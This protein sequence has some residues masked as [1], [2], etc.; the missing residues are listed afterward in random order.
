MDKEAGACGSAG[1]RSDSRG[2]KSDSQPGAISNRSRESGSSD[3]PTVSFPHARP[4][5]PTCRR[6][7]GA[8]P[9]TLPTR[10]KPSHAQDCKVLCISVASSELYA[11]R[12]SRTE[13]AWTFLRSFGSL[14]GAW[15]IFLEAHAPTT[16]SNER[17]SIIRLI[18]VRSRLARK[19]RIKTRK[20]MNQLIN[21]ASNAHGVTSI[22]P[23]THS[24][25]SLKS[26]LGAFL[27]AAVLSCQFLSEPAANAAAPGE[28]LW[29]LR[30]GQIIWSCPAI[31]SDGTIYFGST[32][33]N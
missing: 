4:Q 3:Q 31:A 30:T 8:P 28:K 9:D 6:S 20:N 24:P 32:D 21:Y 23:S 25:G 1:R 14:S 13:S 29:E 26:R 22:N 17:H 11:C 12:Y 10:R 18:A 27:L 7:R 16:R 15:R 19:N 5:S 2:C 33:R